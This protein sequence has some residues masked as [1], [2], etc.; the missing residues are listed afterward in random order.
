MRHD[1]PSI[2]RVVAFFDCQNLFNAAKRL[3]EYSF[4]NFDPVKL[5]QMA[6]AKHKEQSWRLESI[7]LYTGIHDKKQRACA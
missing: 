5:A 1:V 7:R 2:K 4:P 6:T 3:W